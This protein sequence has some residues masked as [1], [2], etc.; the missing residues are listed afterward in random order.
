MWLLQHGDLKGIRL[1]TVMSSPTVSDP[2][3]AR[4]SSTAFLAQSVS[5][6]ESPL[7]YCTDQTRHQPTPIQAE[8]VQTYPLT[9]RS[10]KTSSAVF[11]SVPHAEVPLFVEESLA[12]RGLQFYKV[13]LSQTVLPPQKVPASL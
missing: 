1:L 12:P 4:Q 6:R 9:K 5:H 3:R 13:D 7:P 11:L 2:D 8:G 10:V